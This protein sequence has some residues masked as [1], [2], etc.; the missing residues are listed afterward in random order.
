MEIMQLV[1]DR[2]IN[3]IS[4]KISKARVGGSDLEACSFPSPLV[5]A[6]VPYGAMMVGLITWRTYICWIQQIRTHSSHSTS[7]LTLLLQSEHKT[8]SGVLCVC[9]L[10]R[11]LLRRVGPMHILEARMLQLVSEQKIHCMSAYAFELPRVLVPKRSEVNTV[12]N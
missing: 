9:R 5:E 7:M 3:N 11:S 1:L 10:A 6:C 12:A 4:S 8:V 2:E